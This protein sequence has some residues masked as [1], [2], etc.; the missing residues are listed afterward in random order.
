M[1]QNKQVRPDNTRRCMIPMGNK[2][3]PKVVEILQK[4]G[5][6]EAIQINDQGHVLQYKSHHPFFNPCRHIARTH[7][8][9]DI[10]MSLVETKLF[11]ACRS[12]ENIQSSHCTNGVNKYV[13]KY[14]AKLGQQN[15]IISKSH[16]CNS[17]TFT[18][19]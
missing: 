19:K 12:M 7:S 17:G 5:L 10:F 1:P 9:V 18:T 13:C 15:Y 11:T 3:S 4:I 8:F 6:F 16:P 14:C 2:Q